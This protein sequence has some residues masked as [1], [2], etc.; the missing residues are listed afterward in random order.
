MIRIKRP[1][2]SKA[3]DKP[4]IKYLLRRQDK[5][6]AYVP[7]S[8]DIQN[9]WSNFLATS[10]KEKIANALDA[11][12]Y[13]KCAYCEQIAAKDIEHF[14][15]K[16][17]YP[18]RMFQW[19]NFLRSCKN[20]NNIKGSQFPLNDTG[21]AVLINPCEEEPLEFF[22]WDVLTGKMVIN[23][24]EPFQTRAAETR[25]LL[26]LDQEPVCEER[27]QKL[28]LIRYL[29]ARVIEEGP[30]STETKSRLQDELHPRR[31]WLGIIRQIF[32]K[33]TSDDSLLVDAA[34]KKLPEI[35]NWIT[36]WL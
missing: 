8:A 19:T 30:V 9:A 29:L 4:T 24:N 17:D 18:T 28:L 3:L 23:P 22:I 6:N 20:C 5:A 21:A 15:P 27:R 25:K 31:P 14:Y 10:A 7:R 34:L 33:P 11:Y 16:S 35:E 12:T 13:A 32:K 36:A 1:L 26:N 2:E